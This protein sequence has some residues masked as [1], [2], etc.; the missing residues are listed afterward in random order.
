MRPMGS[1]RMPHF[2]RV[3]VGTEAENTRFLTALDT[4]LAAAS[5]DTAS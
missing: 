4:V 5:A 3:T 2:L 1:Y